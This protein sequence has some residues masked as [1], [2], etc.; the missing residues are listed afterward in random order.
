VGL[1]WRMPRFLKVTTMVSW[2]QIE[3]R[4]YTSDRFDRATFKSSRSRVIAF[5]DAKQ[6]AFTLQVDLTMHER[7]SG[8]EG[9]VSVVGH[10]F[11]FSPAVPHNSKL[12]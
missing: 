7:R 9:I 11:R 2:T 6:E 3:W 10:Q 12:N 5:G 1:F 8:T 4:T